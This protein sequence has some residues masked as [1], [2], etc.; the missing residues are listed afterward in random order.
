MAHNDYDNTPDPWANY[1]ANL[2]AMLAAAAIVCAFY[3]AGMALSCGPCAI[4][5]GLWGKHKGVKRWTV[6]AGIFGGI[7]ALAIVG[8][9][10]FL[11]FNGANVQ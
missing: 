5:F 4:G 6:W 9:K 7:L 2:A 10:I 1:F 3:M 8:L 11:A